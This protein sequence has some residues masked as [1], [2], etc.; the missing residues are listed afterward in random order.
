MKGYLTSLEFAVAL[1]AVWLGTVSSACGQVDIEP[2]LIVAP[3]VR[4]EFN[5]GLV[6]VQAPFVDLY[7]HGPVCQNFEQNPNCPPASAP[8]TQPESL[9][10]PTG[11]SPAPPVSPSEARQNLI[12]AAGALDRSLGQY[13]TA[14]SWR[15]YLA[16]GAG[17]ALSPTMLRTA[18]FT[19]SGNE[20]LSTILDRYD[21]T[22]KNSDY[23]LISSLPAFRQ[24]R[25]QL[26]A[27]LTS[28]ARQT[29]DRPPVPGDVTSIL[30]PPRQPYSWGRRESTPLAPQTAS[31]NSAPLPKTILE[32]K[33]P[34]ELPVP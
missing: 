34:E 1:S 6:H 5:H 30:V 13:E 8:M 22:T 20:T 18:G 17:E 32:T 2:G 23:R 10:P 21:A 29:D 3:F 12:A 33:S 19:K 4:I 26:A 16:V 25:A 7:T 27:Y 24:T 15:H 9:P 31:T 11:Q 28:L 14:A